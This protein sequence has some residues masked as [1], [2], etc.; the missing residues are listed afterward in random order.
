MAHRNF[1]RGDAPPPHSYEWAGVAKPPKGK[2][3]P[4]V[5]FVAVSETIVVKRKK[6]WLW[7]IG[8]GILGFLLGHKVGSY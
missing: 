3:A 7:A 6:P 8:G 4:P 1:A 2:G 5:A